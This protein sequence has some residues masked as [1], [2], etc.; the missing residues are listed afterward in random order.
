MLLNGICLMMLKVRGHFVT[1]ILRLVE[2]LQL[3]REVLE[4]QQTDLV[5][6]CSLNLLTD[7]VSEEACMDRFKLFGSYNTRRHNVKFLQPIIA[8]KIKLKL[9]VGCLPSNLDGYID[10]VSLT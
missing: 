6:W 3:Q 9:Q 7:G 4:H 5:P 8:S 10:R 2:S 1:Q